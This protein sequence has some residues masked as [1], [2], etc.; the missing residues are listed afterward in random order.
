MCS[1]LPAQNF[2][3]I[4][5]LQ[6]SGGGGAAE[7]ANVSMCK[8]T[9]FFRGSVVLGNLQSIIKLKPLLLTGLITSQVF[10]VGHVI[11]ILA[12]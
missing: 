6:F 5:C 3:L 4:V 9:K 7:Q 12:N 10:V 2:V 1:L 11:L 8:T